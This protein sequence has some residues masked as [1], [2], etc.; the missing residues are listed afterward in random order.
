MPVD[1]VLCFIECEK[2]FFKKDHSWL[3]WI[4]SAL[5]APAGLFLCYFRT[6]E[7]IAM[8]EGKTVE[9]Y[10]SLCSSCQKTSLDDDLLA[11]ILREE[12]AFA[13]LLA[14]Y[15]TAKIYQGKRVTEP[16]AR[17][18]AGIQDLGQKD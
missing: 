16:N 2:P 6:R 13:R 4:L 17:G 9:F 12:P 18:K 5:A 15:P 14:K 10:L 1:R 8:S 3:L 11:E 7:P